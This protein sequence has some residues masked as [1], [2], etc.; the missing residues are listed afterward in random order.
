MQGR[1]W[2]TR[3]VET[4]GPAPCQPHIRSPVARL[5]P[6]H[7]APPHRDERKGQ[8]DGLDDVQHLVEPVKLVVGL[9]HQGHCRGGRR[10]AQQRRRGRVSCS[11]GQGLQQLWVCPQHGLPLHTAAAPPGWAPRPPPVSAGTS[12][13]RRVASMR[14]QPL[15]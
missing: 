10:N 7:A 2:V 15:T 14:A 11:L 6:L 9:A 4:G 12:A 13:T 8:L 5:Q 1:R 3:G